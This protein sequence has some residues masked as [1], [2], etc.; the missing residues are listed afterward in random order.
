M[1]L[2]TDN[3]RKNKKRNMENVKETRDEFS[4]TYTLSFFLLF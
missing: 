3:E 2:K 4:S 1:A